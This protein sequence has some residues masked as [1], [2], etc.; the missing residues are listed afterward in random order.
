MIYLDSLKKHK[1]GTY[2]HMVADDIEELHVFAE[3][4]GL[5][6]E[7]LHQAKIQHYDLTPNKRILAVKK[8]AVEVSSREIILLDKKKRQS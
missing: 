3:S 6:R 7:Y 5:K 8:G 4:L 1:K 2:C